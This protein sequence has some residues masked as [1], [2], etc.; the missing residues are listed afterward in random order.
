MCARENDFAIRAKKARQKVGA[1]KVKN[2]V[3]CWRE[4]R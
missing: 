1:Q 3:K 4:K 2:G